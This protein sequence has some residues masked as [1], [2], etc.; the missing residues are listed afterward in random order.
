L[1]LINALQ[2]VAKEPATMTTATL[3]RRLGIKPREAKAAVREMVS[4]GWLEV[5]EGVL[6]LTADGERQ[7]ER[8]S[9]R[10]PKFFR[11]KSEPPPMTPQEQKVW[12]WLATNPGSRPAEVGVAI[13]VT[14]V[15]A[16]VVVK[17]MTEAGVLEQVEGGGYRVTKLSREA[18]LRAVERGLQ[19]L[20]ADVRAMLG[21]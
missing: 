19:G 21:E 7:V 11:T 16:R 8:T 5:V 2:A 1:A 18:R 3:A 9:V 13:D 17:R 4:N 14:S 15:H 10:V 6:L 20:L 12:R